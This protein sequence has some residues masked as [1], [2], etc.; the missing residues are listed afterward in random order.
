MQDADDYAFT[1]HYSSTRL[2]KLILALHGSVR[3]HVTGL[4]ISMLFA[5]M[6]GRGTGH[7]FDFQL[8]TVLMLLAI[9]AAIV[10]QLVAMFMAKS[11]EPGSAKAGPAMAVTFGVAVVLLLP[12]TLL[13]RATSRFGESEVFDGIAWV[14][15]VLLIGLILVGGLVIAGAV[16]MVL[17]RTGDTHTYGFLARNFVSAGLLGSGIF[18]LVSGIAAAMLGQSVLPSL[19][20]PASVDTGVYEMMTYDGVIWLIAAM[21][22]LPVIR[23]GRTTA[24]IIYLVTLY[25]DMPTGPAFRIDAAG[26]AL[27][28]P[29]TPGPDRATWNEIGIG[30]RSHALTPG[31]ELVVRRSGYKPWSV[32]F[33]YLDV[34]PGTIDSAIR[35]ATL[36]ARTLNLRRLDRIV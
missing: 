28:D 18:C 10:G 2:V 15:M 33:L 6:I 36:G 34:L 5:V 13:L 9:V 27:A 8:P 24:N 25:E 29:D 7:N 11:V 17:W 23:M 31:A 14:P 3:G 20:I 16:L 35:S 12:P 19:D 21:L 30:T 1:A 26:V 32:P 4:I 22:A